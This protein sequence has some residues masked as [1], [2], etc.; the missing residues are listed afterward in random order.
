MTTVDYQTTTCPKCGRPYVAITHKKVHGNLVLRYHLC[1]ICG[2][3]FRSLQ[4]VRQAQ[5][6]R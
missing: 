3:R 4:R 1:R 2:E 6:P 5:K